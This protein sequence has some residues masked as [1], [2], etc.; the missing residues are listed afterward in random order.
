M[1]TDN[2]LRFAYGLKIAALVLWGIL[3]IITCAGVWNANPEGFVKWCAAA[4]LLTNGIVLWR[5]AKKLHEGYAD[6]L[7]EL[8]ETQ[9]K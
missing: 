3:T 4:L 6:A 5:F 1:K 8:S 9:K 2:N 7:R